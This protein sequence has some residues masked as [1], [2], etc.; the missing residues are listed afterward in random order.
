MTNKAEIQSSGVRP[1]VLILLFASFSVFTNPV[2]GQDTLSL[3]EAVS[4]AMEFNYQIRLAKQEVKIATNNVTRGNAGFLPRLDV[5]LIQDNSIQSINAKFITGDELRNP[6]A[7]SNSLT[8]A[9]QLGWTLF[10]GMKMFTTWEKLQEL[11][12][13]GEINSRIAIENTV[14][15]VCA[16]YYDLIRQ[17]RQIDVLKE[18]LE[19]S[20]ERS[21]LAEEKF[22]LGSASRREMLLAQVDINTDRSELMQQQDLFIQTKIELNRL[23]GRDS[24]IEFEVVENLDLLPEFDFLQLKEKTIN[25]NTA[26]VQARQEQQIAAL[27]MKEIRAER[28]PVIDLNMGYNFNRSASEAGFLLTNQVQGVNYG[29][30]AGFN[31]FNGMN[32]NRRIQNAEISMETSAIRSDQIQNNLSASLSRAYQA[33]ASNLELL[34]LEKENLD[35]AHQNFEIAR[36]TYELGEL[37]SIEFREAQI[38]H[39]RSENRL[40][41]ALY[42][43]KINEIELLLLSGEIGNITQ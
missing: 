4:E 3:F 42:Q 41:Q 28:Y 29:V 20:R 10:D 26:L 40:T 35:V 19:F 38:N 31:I 24:E 14:A 15:D 22:N 2:R 13:L 43:V 25:Q 9:A 23:L 17:S 8:A 18:S 12:V 30:S 16:V 21:K 7:G 39:V 33:Y 1:V 11:K 6:G 5:N 32:L 37:S 34:D 36:Q 27:S